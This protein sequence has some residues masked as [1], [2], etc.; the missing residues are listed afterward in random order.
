MWY[1]A[2]I[3][4]NYRIIVQSMERYKQ[5]SSTVQQHIPSKYTEEMSTASKVVRLFN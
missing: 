2:Y 3:N 1:V 5:D 4:L